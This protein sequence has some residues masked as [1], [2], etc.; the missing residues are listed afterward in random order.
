[1]RTDKAF[2]PVGGVAMVARVVSALTAGGASGVICVGGD[3]ARLRRLGLAWIADEWPGEGPLGGLV[4]ALGWSDEAS[5]VVAACD[6]PWL[7]ARVI[8]ALVEAHQTSAAPVTIY[9]VDGTVQPLPGV[10][11]AW[12]LPDLRVAWE[13]G[14]RA[15]GTALSLA[16]PTI[17][18]APDP[19]AL[20][21][22]DEP[23][24]LPPA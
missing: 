1:M 2:V 13:R 10:Y 14:D 11:D 18:D 16:E 8:R 19:D 20:R 4:T 7:D 3:A 17:V 24:D 6:Q 23:G 21:D 15:L 22:V 12:L 9:R 5:V